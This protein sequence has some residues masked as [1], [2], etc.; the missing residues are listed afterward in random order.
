MIWTIQKAKTYS[1]ALSEEKPQRKKTLIN[2]HHNDR[3]TDSLHDERLQKVQQSVIA[4]K[5]QA[6][7]ALHPELQQVHRPLL[8]THNV[9]VTLVAPGE[10]QRESAIKTFTAVLT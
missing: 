6:V 7:V 10:T 5:V 3:S 8:R 9:L 2:K 4:F 1:L